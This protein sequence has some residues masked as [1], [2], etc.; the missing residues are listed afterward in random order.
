MP[1]EAWNSGWTRSLAMMLNGTTLQVSDEDGN[2]LFDDSFLIVVNASHEGVEFTL[3]TVPNTAPWRQV[4]DTEN[5]E[6]PFKEVDTGDK[7]IVGG[8]SLKVFTD[9]HM[10][11][12]GSYSEDSVLSSVSV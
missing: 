10:S 9:C 1:E 7:I 12:I 4:V 3:P 8:R 6:D 2:P 11:V 5:I